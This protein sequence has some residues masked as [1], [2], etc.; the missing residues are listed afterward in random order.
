MSMRFSDLWAHVTRRRAIVFLPLWLAVGYSMGTSILLGPVRWWAVEVRT[1]AWPS[2]VETAGVLALILVLVAASAAL[3]ALLTGLVLGTRRL[4]VRLGAP[5]LALAAAGGS[6]WLWL[7]PEVVAPQEL[8]RPVEGSRFTFGPYPTKARL[9]RLKEEG[10]QGV[11]SLLH[12]AVVPFEP[13]LIEKEAAN[14][15]AVGIELIHIPVLPWVSR[16]SGAIEEMKELAR[17][18]EGRFYVHCYLGQDRVNLFRRVVGEHVPTAAPTRRPRLLK[19]GFPLERGRVVKLEDGVY[20]TGMP[21]DE[22]Y[23]YYVLNTGLETVVSLLDPAEEGTGQWIE[24]ERKILDGVGIHLV[25][26]P[27]SNTAPDRE[28]TAEVAR[29]VRSMPR[30]LLVHDFL[31]PSTG[32]APA[33]ELFVEEYR[34]LLPPWYLRFLHRAMPD[35]VVVVALAPWLLVVATL[36]AAWV[37]RLRVRRGVVT[38][39]TRKIF[40]LVIFSLAGVLQLTGGLSLVM[41]YGSVVACV[42]LYAV[43]RGEGFPFYEALARPTDRPHRTLFVLVPL[44]TT[45]VGGVLANLLFPTTAFIGYLVTGWGDAVG[46]PVGTAWGRHRYRVPSLAGVPATR[47]LEGSSAVF[48]VSFAAAFLGLAA[49]GLPGGRAFGVALACAAGSTAVEA[50]SSHGLDNLTLQVAAAG[51]AFWLLG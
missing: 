26:I 24:H 45:A 15:A 12:P 17:S 43:W 4:D 31:A 46:E 47:S 27:L 35:P 9:Q 5:L 21:T 16:N 3:A 38:P 18:T 51:I 7:Q 33:A 37:G 11:V 20:L 32:R 28:R 34:E 39:Y 29:E 36:A 44:A 40:H 13:V 10:Y 30:P 2:A 50:V 22:E 23:L 19:D 25:E 6:V 14:A 41:L 48:L 8:V 42:V 1:Q 49:A